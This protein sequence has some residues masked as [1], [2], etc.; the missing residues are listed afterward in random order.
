MT[1]DLV[2]RWEATRSA[3]PRL[4]DPAQAAGACQARAICYEIAMRSP[5]LLAVALLTAS[6][7]TKTRYDDAIDTLITVRDERDLALTDAAALDETVAAMNDELVNL[8]GQ[9]DRLSELLSTLERRNADLISDLDVLSERLAKMRA[10]GRADQLRKAELKTLI[11]R[12]QARS[13]A[14]DEEAE[15][16]R[17]RLSTLETEANRLTEEN[18]RLSRLRVTHDALIA[19][20]Q[21]EIT[22]GRITITELSGKLVVNVSNEILFDSGSI[23]LREDG[24]ASLTRVASALAAHQGKREIRVEGHTDDV[25]VRSGATFADNWALSALR[26]ATVVSV[27]VK[28]GVDPLQIAAVGFGPH[29]P[30]ASNETAEGRRANR[31]TEIVL[32]PQLPVTGERNLDAAGAPAAESPAAKPPA[33]APPATGSGE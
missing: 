24:R 26:A 28:E 3:R 8:S 4:S 14:A 16:V 31:R 32:I 6:C 23:E 7:V 9:H 10:A 2:E 1:P 12:L 30:A 17:E 33:A 5:T 27:L 18:A 22:A 21:G 20:L 29:H 13:N 11:D 25:P 19:D 15:R